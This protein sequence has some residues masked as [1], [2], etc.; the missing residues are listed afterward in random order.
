LVKNEL[1]LTRK[2]VGTFSP[3]E[4]PALRMPEGYKKSILAW[5]AYLQRTNTQ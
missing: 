3:E 4:I 1:A 2:A 5:L